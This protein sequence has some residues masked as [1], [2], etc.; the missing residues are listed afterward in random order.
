MTHCFLSTFCYSV[1]VSNNTEILPW[2]DEG[3]LSSCW[4]LSAAGACRQKFASLI[5]NPLL[6]RHQLS[7]L[8]HTADTVLSALHMKPKGSLQVKSYHWHLINCIVAATEYQRHW[9]VTNEDRFTP[10][11]SLAWTLFTKLTLTATFSTDKREQQMVWTHLLEPRDIC[12]FQPFFFFLNIYSF[13]CVLM[14]NEV[15]QHKAQAIGTTNSASE[16][17]RVGKLK[18]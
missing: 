1:G 7:C 2:K 8:V 16:K 10:Q 15:R 4:A 11:Q 14:S 9:S 18:K 3:G 17:Y 12:S 13:P 6:L 5:F